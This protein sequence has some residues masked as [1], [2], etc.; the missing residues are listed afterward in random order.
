MIGHHPAVCQV[1]IFLELY[2]EHFGIDLHHNALKP[3]MNTFTMLI[4]I[5]KHLNSFTHIVRFVAIGCRCKM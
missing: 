4:M 3:I 5:T 1:N 2:C